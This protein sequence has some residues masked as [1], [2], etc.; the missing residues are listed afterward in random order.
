MNFSYLKKFS[1]HV[2]FMSNRFVLFIYSFFFVLQQ[3]H[4]PQIGWSLDGYNIYGRHLSATNLGYST[5]L[6]DCGG[7]VHGNLP[8]HYHAQVLSSVSDEGV[9][10]GMKQGVD[11]YASTTG[12]YK[13]FKGDISKIPNYWGKLATS[14]VSVSPDTTTSICAGSKNYYTAKGI[15][16]PSTSSSPSTTPG[17][18]LISSLLF[19]S[20]Y[21]TQHRTIR[22]KISHFLLS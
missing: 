8:Y 11:Y 20:Y 12:P 21:P 7:H 13:C 1:V 3:S 17:K 2:D 10:N 16:L 19:S 22:I 18:I 5:K 4:P 14:H 15:T 9:A 6:D